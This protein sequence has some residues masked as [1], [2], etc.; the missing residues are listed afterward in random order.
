MGSNYSARRGSLG[1]LFLPQMRQYRKFVKIACPIKGPCCLAKRPRLVDMYTVNHKNKGRCR[2]CLKVV[3][4][5]KKIKHMF[6]DDV[7]FRFVSVSKTGVRRL[8]VFLACPLKYQ[9]CLATEGRWI[10]YLDKRGTCKSCAKFRGGWKDDHG[11]VRSHLGSEHRLI[12]QLFLGRK[13]RKWETVH[14]KNGKRADNRL[15]NLELKASQHG[16]GQSI[17]DL[18]DYIL[19]IPK[20]LGGLGP[21]PK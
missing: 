1:G 11:Y 21:N 16:P 10:T 2:S 6:G 15:E 19:S 17:A 18:R 13:L 4:S 12:M 3:K 20:K 9:S 5:I 14:H 8:E 7:K